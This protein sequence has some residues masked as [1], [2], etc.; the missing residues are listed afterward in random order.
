MNE[1]V[2]K[3]ETVERVE[4]AGMVVELVSRETRV[5]FGRPG[6]G[7][8]FVYRRPVRV[9]SSDGSHVGIRDHVMVMRVAAL[10]AGALICVWRFGRWTTG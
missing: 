7:F 1:A 5:R 9:V 3:R 2:L 8:G 10:I 4:S 6:F